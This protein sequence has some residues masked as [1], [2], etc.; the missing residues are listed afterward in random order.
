[1]Y[2]QDPRDAW[3][4]HMTHYFPSLFPNDSMFDL[5]PARLEALVVSTQ[6][7]VEAAEQASTQTRP[8]ARRVQ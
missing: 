1:M 5:T 3:T 4:P 2:A 8:K 7:S 6:K